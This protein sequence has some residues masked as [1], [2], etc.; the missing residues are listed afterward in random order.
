M[1]LPEFGVLLG[2][3]T[4]EEIDID[5]YRLARHKDFDDFIASWWPLIRDAPWLGKSRVSTMRD[6]LHRSI[7]RV[8]AYTIVWH[9]KSQEWCTQTD[10]FYSHSIL[11]STS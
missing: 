9:H 10:L 8:L 1:S 11:A 5:L 2:L 6:P 4:T 3:Y 7:H